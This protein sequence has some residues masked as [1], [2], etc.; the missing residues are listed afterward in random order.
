MAAV[1]PHSPRLVVAQ[2]SASAQPNTVEK[3]SFGD[4]SGSVRWLKSMDDTAWNSPGFS[5]AGFKPLPFLGDHVQENGRDTV[6][7]KFVNSVFDQHAH[8]MAVH[9]PIYWKPISSNIVEL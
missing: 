4:S 7:G 6:P 8:I 9:G 1:M 2:I 3:E 5:S